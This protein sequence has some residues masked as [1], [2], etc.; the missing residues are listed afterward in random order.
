MTNLDWVVVPSVWWENSPLVIQE[1][2][3]FRRPV[4][5]SDIG[6]MAEKVKHGVNGLHF[7]AGDARSLAD[8]IRTAAGTP[9]LWERLREGIQPVHP[10]T[11]HVATLT[12]IYNAL[13]RHE[14]E[15]AHAG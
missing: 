15:V 5:C 14:L 4:I 12:E 3:H 2:F 1:S 7:R 8:T 11:T 13:L 10:M 6:G 9:G